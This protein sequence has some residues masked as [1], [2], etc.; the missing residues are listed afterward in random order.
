MLISRKIFL[1]QSALISGAM[2]VSSFGAENLLINEEES[3]I[4]F[5]H[6]ND[7]HGKLEP[8]AADAG[9]NAG[10]GG[11]AARAA[12][13][14]E[15]RTETNNILLFDAGDFFQ[16][17]A[18]FNL[19]KGEPEIKAM[20]EMKYDAATLGEHDF[21]AGIESLAIQVAKANFSIVCSNYDFTGTEL[22]NKIVPYKIFQKKNIKVGVLGVGIELN[23]LIE[24]KISD[25]I[26]YMEPITK[27]NDTAALLRKQGCNF[28]VCL[29]HLGDKY[30]DAKVSDEILA[31]QSYDIDLIIGGH[32]HKF[33]YE[34]K[35]YVNKKNDDVVVNQVG[36][37]G[38]QLGRL[39]YNF[40]KTGKKNL[41]KAHTV[42]IGKKTRE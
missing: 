39:D 40:I 34:P 8:F 38:L 28:I 21:E 1:K 31:K 2:V 3:E 36:W 11:V 10:L 26:K 23:G 32:T 5:L 22:E 9:R 37:A 7:V 16:K 19:Y 35:K 14:K 27:A 6:T 20:N 29:S 42:V 4:T 25:K 13:I 12:L 24:D 33:F 15:I 17:N 41:T 30:D 18:L